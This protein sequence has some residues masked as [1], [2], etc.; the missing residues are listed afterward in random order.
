[1][2]PTIKRYV[3]LRNSYAIG[4][5]KSPLIQYVKGDFSNFNKARKSARSWSNFDPV[6]YYVFDLKTQKVAYAY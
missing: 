1:M 2:T 5:Q 3:V 4:I 6:G